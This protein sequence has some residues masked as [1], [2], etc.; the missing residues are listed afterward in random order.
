MNP[1]FWRGK[2]VFLTGHTGFK[3]GWLAL[4][5]T[6]LGAEVSGYA[7]DSPT[8]PNFFTLARLRERLI[9]HHCA[10]VR[11]ATDL[12]QALTAA[13][14]DVVFHLAAQPLVRESYRS[15]VATYAT[16][17]MGTINLLEAVRHAATVRAVVVV[18]SDKCYANQ[19]W[20][21]PY[22]ETD[23]LGGHDPYA[24]SK[25]CAELV[26]AAYRHSFLA[27][28]GVAVATARAGNVI[29]GG[30]W[31]AER[32][33]PDFLRALD[34]EMALTI[35]SPAAIRPWQ[36]VLEPLAGYLA[37]AERLHAGEETAA[38]WNFG[39]A[40]S[41]ARSVRWVLETL[42]AHCPTARWQCDSAPQPAEAGTLQV[43]SALARAQ[44]HWKPRWT[45]EQALTATLEWHRAWRQDADLQ[46]FSLRQI[47]EYCGTAA[48]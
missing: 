40:E 2:R 35:R 24:S 10:D 20:V 12:Q 19:E 1:I 17:I 43:D 32:L 31:A 38:A 41:E 30:D 26:T 48:P 22:R 21:W 33:L 28:A 18:T 39:P 11:D 25:A 44:L 4:W 8:N 34:A 45:L 16:N 37:L 3:G 13:A 23:A 42:A 6:E 46:Q 36:H 14:P 27:A 29:G 15:P 9:A 47:T 7:L 5:L